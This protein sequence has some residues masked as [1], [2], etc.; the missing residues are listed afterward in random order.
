ME[1]ET[2]YYRVGL[3]AGLD[4][5][6]F[7]LMA[8]ASRKLGRTGR[9]MWPIVDPSEI[10][11]EMRVCKSKAEID[12]LQA[13]ANISAEAHATAM[14]VTKPGMFEYEV[15]AV[16]YHAFRA[17]GASRLGYESIV[18]S[19]PNACTL[20]YVNN[21]RR[22]TEKDLLLVDAGAEFD[23]YTADITR[24]FPVCGTFT[25]EQREVYSA[26]LTA[27]K[28]CIKMARPEKI[29]LRHPPKGA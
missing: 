28:E 19:G 8:K 24:V 23:Y 2:L 11:G 10:L 20:H 27:Q 12:R 18:A 26:V 3:D 17:N 16:L 22:M 15:E 13:A 21:D 7:S 29:D 6:I 1:A 25:K 9:S 14:R 4:Q 5:R